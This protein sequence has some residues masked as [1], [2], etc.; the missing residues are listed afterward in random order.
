MIS[1]IR[2][3]KFK[4]PI[5]ADV[6]IFDSTNSHFVKRVIDRES[7]IFEYNTRPPEIWIGIK[8]IAIFLQKIF[9]HDFKENIRHKKGRIYGLFKYLYNVY[10]ESMLILINPKF[11]IT[12]IDNSE[13]FGWLTKNCREFPFIAI[14]NGG[15]LSYAASDL[16]GYHCQHLFCFGKHEKDL[17]PK[18]G[19]QVDNF[20]PVGSL[21]SSLYFNSNLNNN[22]EKYDLLIVS[23]WRG[24][25]GFPKDVKDTMRSMKIMDELLAK[26]INSRKIKAAIILR[27]EENSEHWY[28]PEIGMSEY[29]YFKNIYGDS[30][31]LIMNDFSERPIY[32][33][34]EQSHMIV[35]V[36]SSALLEA[37]GIGK[38]ALYYNF[39]GTDEYHKDFDAA[40]VASDSNEKIFTDQ[41]DNLLNMS[42]EEY[43][44]KYK[45]LQRYYM[46]FPKNKSTYQYILDKI[47]NIVSSHRNLL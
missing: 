8:V 35:S 47:N 40:I 45:D 23:T 4:T 29:D 28:M 13:L 26:Y 44:I 33:L 25:I 1:I 3:I 20:Y 5:K 6:V 32:K 15:R 38:K 17:F 14:Q 37:F 11:V 9:S 41:L 31:D 34:I 7:S 16:P 19:Y 39:C 24:N 27:S 42:V 43:S 22:K 12:F 30:T 46:S 2:S 21:V 36:L 10:I 18:I